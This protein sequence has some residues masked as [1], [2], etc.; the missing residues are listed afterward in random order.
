MLLVIQ[1]CTLQDKQ[2]KTVR[3][4]FINCS[5]FIASMQ[6]YSTQA[7][8]IIVM[9]QMCIISSELGKNIHLISFLFTSIITINKKNI[10][11]FSFFNTKTMA[12][13]KDKG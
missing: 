10:Y 6:T 8:L 12:I 11:F 2:H 13:S 7:H 1:L 9:H 4:T 5:A 3:K